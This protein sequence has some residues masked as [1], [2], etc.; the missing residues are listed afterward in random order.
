MG[1]TM[2]TMFTQTARLQF[3]NTQALFEKRLCAPASLALALSLFT[4]APAP[5]AQAAE[6]DTIAVGSMY[7]ALFDLTAE[8][9]TLNWQNQ[10][11]YPLTGPQVL[12]PLST[13]QP[14]DY[15]TTSLPAANLLNPHAHGGLDASSSRFF[16]F[17]LSGNLRSFLADNHYAFAIQLESITFVGTPLTAD[18]VSVFYYNAGNDDWGV[19]NPA[20]TE[21]NALTSSNYLLWNGLSFSN[22]L[23][24]L[25][26]STDAFAAEYT[27]NYTVSIVQ[28]TLGADINAT[29][30]DSVIPI[31]AIS[32]LSFSYTAESLGATPV[33][34]PATYALLLGA[35][36][37]AIACIH[38]KAKQQS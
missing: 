29:V 19:E 15:Y 26:T 20:K 14:G 16:G 6:L 31:E 36:L 23:H 35:A 30:L 7:M 10:S 37:A 12:K 32:A 5:Q 24:P 33:P 25:V 28:N 9:N 17:S 3:K 4:L 34:E 18:N 22:M 38:R 2:G 21:W 11:D 27:L 8:S 13:T 1:Y